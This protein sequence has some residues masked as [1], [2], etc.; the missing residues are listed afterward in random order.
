M[1]VVFFGRRKMGKVR[2][3]GL[4]LFV[5]EYNTGT[6]LGMMSKYAEE[7]LGVQTPYL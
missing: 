6:I 7:S 4:N 5:G 1:Y 2:Y 3:W